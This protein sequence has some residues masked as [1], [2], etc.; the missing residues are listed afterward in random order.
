[1]RGWAS[2]REFIYTEQ[3]IYWNFHPFRHSKPGWHRGSREP[4]FAERFLLLSATPATS[5]R[6][7]IDY[8]EILP[9][10]LNLTETG[11]IDYTPRRRDLMTAAQLT[12]WAEP[13][14]DGAWQL[15]RE[16]I[17]SALNTGKKLSELINLLENRV[18]PPETVRKS[19]S[20]QSSH[21][22]SNWLCVPGL[23]QSTQSNSRTSS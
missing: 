23:G 14:A 18:S 11:R 9:D 15:T 13:T 3:P 17:S 2:P 19:H 16:S 20:C 22:C 10:N 21:R 12:L 8:A 4:S 6:I 5:G 1:M 7:E